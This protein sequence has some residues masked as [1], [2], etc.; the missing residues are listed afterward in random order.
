MDENN[1]E[2]KEKKLQ[3]KAEEFVRQIITSKDERLDEIGWVTSSTDDENTFEDKKFVDK[4]LTIR[5]A[6]LSRL[7]GKPYEMYEVRGPMRDSY[8]NYININ[9]TISEEQSEKV[10]N[11]K[12]RMNKIKEQVS[13]STDASLDEPGAIE[14]LGILYKD[15]YSIDNYF[16]D[17]NKW[18][19]NGERVPNTGRMKI[20]VTRR[21]LM[22]AGLDPKD[23]DW[24]SLEQI[25][26]EQK[27]WEQVTAKDFAEVDKEQALAETELKGVKG[28]IKG[29]MEKI[30][31]IFKGKDEK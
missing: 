31:K 23:F 17:W 30:K 13:S 2:E 26:S 14:V 6:M 25:K 5:E 11:Y 8:W 7:L 9:P 12:E 28:F 4:P 1:I 29:L 22:E 27:K 19:T 15:D 3:E 24:K 21:E 18:P 16:T 10:E 20:N